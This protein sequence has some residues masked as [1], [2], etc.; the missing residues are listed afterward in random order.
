MAIKDNK[1]SSLGVILF[2]Q[3]LVSD[4]II[5]SGSIDT[6]DYDNGITIIPINCAVS[7]ETSFNVTNIQDSPDD[8]N[9][10]NIPSNQLIGNWPLPPYVAPGQVSGEVIETL[11]VIGNNRYI[12]VELTVSNYTMAI[13]VVILAYVGAE[14]V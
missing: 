14:V 7:Q 4:G 13:R 1:S 2:N 3:N 11:G 6:F 8:V 5:Y 10:T 9:W 12:R